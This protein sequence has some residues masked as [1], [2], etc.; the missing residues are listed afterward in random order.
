MKILGLYHNACALELFDWIRRQGNEVVCRTERITPKWC[1]EQG[2]ELTVSYTYRY[3]LDKAVLDALDNNVVNI[4]NAYLP[5]NRGADPNLWSIIDD[6]PR[7]ITLHYMDTGL[8]K[9]SIIAQRLVRKGKAETLQSSYE[10][11]DKAAKELFVEAFDYYEDWPRMKKYPLGTG[12]YHSLKDG[13]K[14][15][16]VIDTYELPVLEFKERLKNILEK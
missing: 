12:T 10:N 11:L 1:K 9:G 4:H 6:T 7:G 3:I 8:D 13:E 15:K 14:M 16:S 5:W 2:F